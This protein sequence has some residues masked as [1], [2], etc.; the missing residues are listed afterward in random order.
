MDA[1][2]LFLCGANFCLFALQRSASIFN[3]DPSAK[4]AL[5][6]APASVISMDKLCPSFYRR[7]RWTALAFA[8]SSLFLGTTTYI[9]TDIAVVPMLWIIPLTLYLLSFILVFGRQSIVVQ[10][11]LARRLPFLIVASTVTI[12]SHA[13]NP[14]WLLIPLHLL[15]FFAA[16]MVCHGELVNDRPEPKH[17]TEFYTWISLGVLPVGYLTLSSHLRS[18]LFHSSIL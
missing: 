17:L 6:S 13:T 18:L 3:R 15:T 9:S 10:E 7:L 4:R 12:F 5:N 11:F 14:P 8:P 2:I 1:R 16:A